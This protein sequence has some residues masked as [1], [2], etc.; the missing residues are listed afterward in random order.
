MHS[1]FFSWGTPATIS[2]RTSVFFLLCAMGSF[3]ANWRCPL[4]GRVDNGAY[5]LD[6]FPLATCTD[7]Y[8]SCLWFQVQDRGLTAGQIY[9]NALEVVLQRHPL[10]TPELRRLV[11]ECLFGRAEMLFEDGLVWTSR[12]TSPT[13]PTEP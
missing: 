13:D 7:G 9:S 11:I 3:P 5:L 10:N 1:F 4:C 2:A 8:F 6:G 12:S